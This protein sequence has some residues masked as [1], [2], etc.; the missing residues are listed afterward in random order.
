MKPAILTLLLAVAFGHTLN[1]EAQL[2]MRDAVTHDQ[3][4]LE[5]RK[6]AQNDPMKKLAPPPEAT[7]RKSIAPEIC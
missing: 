3:L 6:A 1:A 7:R 5:T 2:P 4:A